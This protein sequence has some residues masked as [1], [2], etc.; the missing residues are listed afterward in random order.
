MVQTTSRCR[1]SCLIGWGFADMSRHFARL[2]VEQV[3]Q[4]KLI[5]VAAML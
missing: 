2:G 5:G 3:V 1:E 4:G